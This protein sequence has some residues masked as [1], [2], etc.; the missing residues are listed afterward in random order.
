MTG[1][2]ETVP[3]ATA[4]DD[5]A[6]VLVGG[7]ARAAYQVGFLRA[8]VTRYPDLKLPIITGSSAGAINAVFLAAQVNPLTEALDR[9]AD[10]WL[11]QRVDQVFRVDSRSL[12]SQVLR[13]GMTL[14]S[15]G[16]SLAPSVQGLLDTSP[17]R[18]FL[19]QSLTPTESGEIAGIARNIAARRL[20]ALAITTSCYDSGRSVIWVQGANIENWERP[21][22][23]SRH[24]HIT[25]DHVMASSAIPFFFPAIKLDDGWYGDGSIR[26]MAPCSPA[27]HLGARRI[28]AISN[29]HQTDGSEEVNP[30]SATYPPPAQ[31]AG[32]LVQSM[33]LDDLDRDEWNLKRLNR[34][35]RQLPASQCEGLRPVEL[36][37]VRPSCDLGRLAHE[38]E[39]RLPALF[40]HM[41][42][43]LGSR[44][45]NSS[46]LLSLLM[47]QKDY[48]ER[49]MEI[50]KDDADRNADRVARLLEGTNSQQPTSGG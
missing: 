34:L 36:V 12:V 11:S 38:F 47:F 22:R 50:G 42:R 25:I 9:L 7:G 45:T 28:L 26:M 3:A 43:G 18:V 29:H 4:E 33:F 27:I 8:L 49:L 41:T 46:A 2:E 23:C 14:I 20:R 24:T 15:G 13:W 39:P 19:E 48:V 35:T 37:V 10:L 44:K 1:P 40:R 30:T 16:G 21:N 31:I 5:L 17:L 32:R 6:L